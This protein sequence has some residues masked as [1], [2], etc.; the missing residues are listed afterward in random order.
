MAVIRRAPYYY[1]DD[2]RPQPAGPPVAERASRF[3]GQRQVQTRQYQSP[4]RAD[5]QR[6]TED[7]EALLVEM[8][9]SR[10]Q[11]PVYDDDDGYD[12]PQR[13]WTTRPGGVSITPYAPQRR[14]GV[15]PLIWVGV[16]FLCMMIAWFL[17]TSGLAWWSTHVTDP[18]QYAGALHGTIVTGVLGGGD[19]QETPSKLIGWNNAGHVQIL[20]IT[21]NAPSK[22]Q[23]IV[24][25]DLTKLDA[26][27][28]PTGAVV[29]L[30]LGD[31]N[32]DGHLDVRVTVYSPAY[33]FPFHRMNMVFLL[34]GDGKGGLKPR[35][36]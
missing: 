25:P 32:S 13:T 30:Q 4:P 8:A 17:T 5:R 21:A 26:F 3:A 29:D 31:Y 9:P 35:Q 7:D 6:I 27:P 16:T 34:Y 28:D 12:P 20:K 10:R 1:P 15:S 19:S 33:D 36:Q 2:V 18:G 11:Q 22:A 23:I 24:G 14:R